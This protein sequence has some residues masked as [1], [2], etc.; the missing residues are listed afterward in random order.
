MADRLPKPRFH[1]GRF[2]SSRAARRRDQVVVDG[3]VDDDASPPTSALASCTR[4]SSSPAPATRTRRT[5]ARD[6]SGDAHRAGALAQLHKI[7]DVPNGFDGTRA[8]GS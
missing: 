5:G 6:R 2:D 8:N 1:E 7:I 4:C 3:T